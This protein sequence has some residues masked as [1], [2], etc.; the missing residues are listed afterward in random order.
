MNDLRAIQG[1]SEQ[2]SNRCRTETL[3]VSAFA[4]LNVAA[5]RVAVSTLTADFL[6]RLYLKLMQA[7]SS[8]VRESRERAGLTQEELA[9]LSRVSVRTVRNLESGQGN[10]GIKPLGQIAQVLGLVLN[11]KPLA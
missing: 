11:L 1:V 7:I 6:N 9:E 2:L 10:I 4:S 3:R 8:T 5:R